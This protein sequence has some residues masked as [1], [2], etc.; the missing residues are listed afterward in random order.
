[1]AKR[2]PRVLLL[3]HDSTPDLFYSFTALDLS[4]SKLLNL[5]SFNTC[6]YQQQRPECRL[7]ASNCRRKTRIPHGKRR[8]AS[9][10]QASTEVMMPRRCSNSRS[11][12]A[13]FDTPNRCSLQSL[14]AAGAGPARACIRYRASALNNT[15]TFWYVYDLHIYR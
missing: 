15:S 9:R 6:K 1:M 3:K 7:S 4:N 13:C 10:S 8:S 5:H 2:G 11:S 14:M 12:N